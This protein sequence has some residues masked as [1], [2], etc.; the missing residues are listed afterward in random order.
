MTLHDL[1]LFVFSL[2]NYGQ[3]EGVV[4]CKKHYQEEVV[5]KNTQTPVV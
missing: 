1:V 2:N 4:Y 5:A 3:A